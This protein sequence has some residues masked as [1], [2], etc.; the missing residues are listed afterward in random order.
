M[1]I[2]I[3]ILSKISQTYKDKYHWAPVAYFC[4]PSY[5]GGR[6]QEDQGLKTAWTNTSVRPNLEKPFTKNGTG[7]VAQGS[8]PSTTRKEERKKNATCFL[9]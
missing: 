4:N 9:P 6:D 8:S 5:S 1:E 2:E 7:G 3:I